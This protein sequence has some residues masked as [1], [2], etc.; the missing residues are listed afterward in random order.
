MIELGALLTGLGIRCEKMDL[1]ATRLI[2]LKWREAFAR[3]VKQRTGSW[4]YN[5]FDWHA[6]SFKFTPALEGAR[7]L[8]AYSTAPLVG[9]Y[10][11]PEGDEL[12]YKCAGKNRPDPAKLSRIDSYVFPLDVSWTMAFTHEEPEIGPF[13]ARAKNR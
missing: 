9:F 1:K 3:P 7:A 8:E 13:F 5:K 2:R 11:L 12:G 10:V 6:F 4:T